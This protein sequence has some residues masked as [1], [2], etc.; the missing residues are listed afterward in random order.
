MEGQDLLTQAVNLLAGK[1]GAFAAVLGWIAAFRITCKLWAPKFQRWM[2]DAIA[3][4]VATEDKADDAFVERLLSARPYRILALLVDLLMSIKL[5]TK[6]GEPKNGAAMKKILPTIVLLITLA[7]VVMFAGCKSINPATGQKE[8]DPIKTAAV[9]AA[10]KPTL[11]SAVRRV[12]EAEPKTAPY[13]AQ[14]ADT[15]VKARDTKA[16]SPEL[17]M[18]ELNAAAEAEGWYKTEDEWVSLALDVKNLALALYGIAYEGRFKMDME[19]GQFLY[20]LTNVMA[21]GLAQGVLESGHQ[22]ALSL[23]A[24]TAM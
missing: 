13:F 2:E 16:W 22:G 20:H 23:R 8:Y 21:A 11:A 6:I 15:F 17:I 4:V 10:I 18:A 12:I 14:A 5:P 1:S 9:E 3:K 24:M 7:G 19:E